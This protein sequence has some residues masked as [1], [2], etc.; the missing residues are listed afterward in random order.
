MRG[1]YKYPQSEFPYQH[2]VDENGRRSRDQPEY[3]LVDTGIF[4]ENRYFE[5]VIEYAKA[6]PTDILIQ[7][8]V[9]NRGPA[10]APITL[11]PTIWMRNTWSWGYPD[12]P[13]LPMAMST[14]TGLTDGGA[15]DSVAIPALAHLEAYVLHCREQGDWLFTDNETNLE[16]LYHQPNPTPFQKDGFHRYV[17]EG[18]AAAIN[19]ARFGTKAARLLQRDLAPGEEWC[20]QLRLRPQAA[21]SPTADGPVVEP[22]GAG[23]DG[24]FAEREADWH[25]FQE[26][27]LP[28]LPPDDRLIHST[29]LAGLLWCKKYYGWSVL[30]W[31]EGDPTQPPPPSNRWQTD[32]ALWSRLHAHNIISMPDSWEYPYFCQ[33]DLMFHAVAFALIDPATA[34]EQCMLLRSAHFTSP[35]AQ[36]PAYEWALS[37]PN[38][39]IGAWAAM[40]IYQIDRKQSGVAD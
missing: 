6:S 37:D 31:L 40:R 17:V 32:T 3:E 12:Q 34:K 26:H 7:I 25:A 4:D 23:F 33:W 21:D 16:R 13:C 38:P 5:V 35:S 11:L 8:R 18:E 9:V 36:T 30:R 15:R 19:P 2:L 14:A 27:L 20:E 29:A 24:I 28:G 10:T 22:F 1:L 39:P